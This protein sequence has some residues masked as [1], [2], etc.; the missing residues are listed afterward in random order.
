M[1]TPR[2]LREE[3]GSLSL[4]FVVAALALLVT[5]GLVVDGGG[6][7]RALQRADAV[8]AEAARAGGQ[9]IVESRAVRGQGAVAHPAQARAA[10]EDYLAAADVAGTVTVIDGTRLRVET[11]VTYDP[12]F[13]DLVGVGT[14]T[15]TGEAEVRLVQVLDGEVTP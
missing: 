4:F 8:A 3:R 13:L 9:A 15:S 12:V 10:A 11:S 5:V 7:I 1:R 6:K 2:R 14:Q